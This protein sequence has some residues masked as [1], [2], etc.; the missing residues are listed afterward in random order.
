M[1][2]AVDDPLAP[3]V[4]ALLADHLGFAHDESPPE[5]VH[6]LPPSRLSDAAVTLVSARDPATHEL[7]GVGALRELDVSHGE[8]KSMHTRAAARGQG[9]ARAILA[10]LLAL[11]RDR[12]YARVSL[13]TGSTDAFAPARSLYAS[14]GFQPCEPF[15]DYTVNDFSACMTL[16]LADSDR[17]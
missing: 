12:G 11:A 2:V 15:A 13:E 4:Q 9:V 3:D 10:R 17:A 6:A 8:V 16:V 7:L 14:V 5:H 1:L